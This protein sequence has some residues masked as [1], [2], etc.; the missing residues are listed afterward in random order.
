[1]RWRVETPEIQCVTVGSGMLE[2]TR[3]FG[4]L[5]GQPGSLPNMK[6]IPRD[7]TTRQLGVNAFH[8]IAEG[9]TFELVSQGGGGFGDPL[10]RDAD[11][12]MQDVVNGIVSVEGARA[13]YGVVVDGAEGNCKIDCQATYTRTRL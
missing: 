13:D 6:V 4:L 1:M 5:G 10:E 12:V 9:D 3:A 8:A 11:Q 2:E 7:G